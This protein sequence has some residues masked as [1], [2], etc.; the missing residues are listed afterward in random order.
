M[1]APCIIAHV[2]LLTLQM[3]MAYREAT[4]PKARLLMK[5]VKLKIINLTLIQNAGNYKMTLCSLAQL[6]FF[7]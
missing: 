1:H 6:I 2:S 7:Y 4:W 3:T 5:H